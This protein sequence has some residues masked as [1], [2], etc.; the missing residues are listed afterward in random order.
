MPYPALEI[1]RSGY[2]VL[3]AEE[4]KE[5]LMTRGQCPSA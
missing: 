2:S 3:D 1:W 4:A 5:A